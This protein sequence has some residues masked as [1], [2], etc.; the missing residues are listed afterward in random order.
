MW[1]FLWLEPL[2]KF[3]QNPAAT[4]YSSPDSLWPA[5]CLN[6]G[7]RRQS[8]PPGARRQV[9][10]KYRQ[11]EVDPLLQAGTRSFSVICVKPHSRVVLAGEATV[12]KMSQQQAGNQAQARSEELTLQPRKLPEKPFQSRS[13]EEEPRKQFHLPP[14]QQLAQSRNHLSHSVLKLHHH[15]RQ[16]S[17]LQ[18]AGC[19]LVDL[20]CC[21]SRRD[22]G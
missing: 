8:A 14:R 16:L 5:A 10:Q 2:E 21:S 15:P 3:W 18:L 1:L 19:R 4:S 9:P 17:Q 12:V 11:R 7:V 6:C 13:K 20:I 22:R